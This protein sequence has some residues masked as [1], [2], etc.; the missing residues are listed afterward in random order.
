MLAG[1][2]FIS[3]AANH[4]AEEVAEQ[5]MSVPQDEE[6][7]D[8]GKIDNTVTSSP[9]NNEEQLP[10]KI[11]E[12]ATT[13]PLEPVEPSEES[14]VDETIDIPIAEEVTESSPPENVLMDEQEKTAINEQKEKATESTD[15]AKDT[16]L[17]SGTYGTSP[18]RIDAQGVLYIDGGEL[19]EAT[20]SVRAPWYIYRSSITKIIFTAP[21]LANAHSLGLFF[22]MNQ[23][24]MIENLEY[25][26][27]S[28][29]GDMRYFFYWCSK[30]TNLDVSGFDTTNVTN[31]S[32][33]FY[34]CS[35]LAA[36]DVSNF[37]TPKIKFMNYMFTNCSKLK[38]LDISAV[39]TGALEEMNQSFSGM[40]Q[41]STLTLGP[42]FQF[43][44]EANLPA[45]PTVEPNT[46]YWQNVG[47]GTVAIPKGDH[48]LTSDQLM[49][50]YTGTM[51]DT[52][53]WQKTLNLESISVKD[54]TLYVNDLWDPADNF[55]SATDKDGNAMDFDPS[56]VTGTVDTSVAGITPITY[57]NGSASQVST[58]TV[59]EN[60]ESIVIR[61][62]VLYVGDKWDPAANFVSATDKDGNS[63]AFDPTMVTGD[64]NV[65]V[66]GNYQVTYTNGSASQLA[67]VTVKENK[68][69]IVVK[70]LTIYVGDTWNP[71]DQFISATDKAGS[72]L[73]FIKEMVSGVVDSKKIG[74]YKVVFRN[75]EAEQQTT[76][77]VKE[78]KE[79]IHAKDSTL[80]VGDSWDP[81]DNFLS[82]TDKE[83][84]SV[85]FEMN[86]VDG[87]VDT[88]KVGIYPVTYKNGR[89]SVSVFIHVVKKETNSK[90][91]PPN[92]NGQTPTDNT[93][94]QQT[95]T[96]KATT[97]PASSTTN[98]GKNLPKTGERHSFAT[99]LGFGI[100]AV[101]LTLIYKKDKKSK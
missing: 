30:L 68:E 27:T 57:T 76:V 66:P 41:L 15:I 94:N 83:G 48:I 91:K 95:T 11:P 86:M 1:N 58:V 63:L 100:L 28:H 54:A 17:A 9:E 101:A 89:K 20:M 65:K 42:N 52:Y 38:A 77:T 98:E 44:P 97:K 75:G 90:P 99:A 92:Q 10:E 40:S 72:P 37:A 93:N 25:L 88:S 82:A 12:E 2:T 60:L 21:T 18:W 78:N 33:M 13:T 46:G 8:D 32:Y 69:T 19:G 55:I 47:A 31:M 7:K 64:V 34:G 56:M 29:V 22:D 71:A 43:L 53:V 80:S 26:D 85:P 3:T 81:L 5:E 6:K 45:I 74:T 36:V 79:T 84:K 24:T 62:S 59:K 73:F 87:S 51:A 16:D 14:P 70:D 35:A 49:A 50:T 23:V 39:S 67:E 4:Y 61:N 96:P